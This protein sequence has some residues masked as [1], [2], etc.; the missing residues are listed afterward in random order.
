MLETVITSAIVAVITSLATAS[1]R[2]VL[3]ERKIRADLEQ[4]EHRLRTELRTEFMAEEAVK[5]L[6]RH[7]KWE[8]RS[9]AEI[10]R[11]VGGFA[12]DELRKLLVRAGAVRFYGK[13]NKEF[14]GLIERNKSNVNTDEPKSDF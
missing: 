2:F 3:Q 7:E 9:F 6:L 5:K 10:Q 12:D 1:W 11:R 13:N 4:Q 14:W 8:K